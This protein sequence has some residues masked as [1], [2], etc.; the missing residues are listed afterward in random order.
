MPAGWYATGL[1]ENG[2]STIDWPIR[3]E[4]GPFDTEEEAREHAAKIDESYTNK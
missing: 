1:K 3:H 2:F 4:Y